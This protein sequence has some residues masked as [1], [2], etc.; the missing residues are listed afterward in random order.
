MGR[1]LRNPSLHRSCYDHLVVI[2][3]H[4][5]GDC[6]RGIAQEKLASR[7]TVLKMATAFTDLEVFRTRAAGKRP[8]RPLV[9]R[10]ER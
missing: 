3:G 1:R 10:L 5:R 6:P 2:P 4:Y 8:E 9:G 7:L